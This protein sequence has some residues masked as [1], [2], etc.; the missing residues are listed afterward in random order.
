MKQA[1]L[2]SFHIFLPILLATVIQCRLP[3]LTGSRF[4]HEIQLPQ[5][6]RAR[7]QPFTDRVVFRK[8]NVNSFETSTTTSTAASTALTSDSATTS[9]DGKNPTATPMSTIPQLNAKKNNT[10]QSTSANQSSLASI[11]F[12][13]FSTRIKGP[14]GSDDQPTAKAE[15]TATGNGT[16]SIAPRSTAKPRV[17]RIRVFQLGNV[18][19]PADSEVTLSSDFYPGLKSGNVIIPPAQNVSK[20]VS[21]K[22]IANLNVTADASKGRSCTS[23]RERAKGF[24]F[25]LSDII[26][27]R[28]C[29]NLSTAIANECNENEV[30]CF[31]PNPNRQAAESYDKAPCGIRRPAK[32]TSRSFEENVLDQ[33]QEEVD[34]EAEGRV[35][36]GLLADE[37]EICWQAAIMVDAAYACGGAIISSWNVITAAHCVQ[38]VDNVKRLRVRLGHQNVKIRKRCSESFEVSQVVFHDQYDPLTFAFDLAIIKLAAPI[39]NANCSCRACLPDISKDAIQ[40]EDCI[41]SGYGTTAPDSSVIGISGILNVGNVSLMNSSSECSQRFRTAPEVDKDFK[42]DDSMLCAIGADRAKLVDTCDLDSGSPL[43]CTSP[44]GTANAY[45]L[46]GVSSWGLPCGTNDDTLLSGQLPVPSVYSDV[47]KSMKWI[48]DVT[49][50]STSSL[51][52]LS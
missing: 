10:V 31:A 38:D 39:T 45:T 52:P 6:L 50:N 49:S 34:Q 2:L 16:Q 3:I 20:P 24:C 21:V 35:I 14:E 42:L 25:A 26:S 17:R 27:G 23:R 41:I 29:S 1:G 12:T 11:K 8:A 22:V 5:G 36:N 47:R 30:C 43:A 51:S 28:A 15:V 46:V 32:A 13:R 37:G 7:S 44:G 33:S 40:G 19:Y 18:S 9:L 48:Q 4:P